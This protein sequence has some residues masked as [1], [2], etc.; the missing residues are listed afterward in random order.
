MLKDKTLTERFMEWVALR[1]SFSE[2][3]A[4]RDFIKDAP[5]GLEPWLVGNYIWETGPLLAK[6][7]PFP[8]Q[9]PFV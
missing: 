8:A 3:E 2:R 5:P 4:F 9:G 6:G 1:L 7:D